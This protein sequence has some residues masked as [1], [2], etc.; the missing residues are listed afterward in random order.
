LKY[1]IEYDLDDPRATQQHR[2]I[3]LSNPF[4]KR[5]YREWYGIFISAVNSLPPGHLLEL[6]SGGGFLKDM[7]PSVITSDILDLPHVEMKIDAEQLPFE[8]KSMGGIFMINVFHHI[9]NP[10]NFLNEVYRTLKPGGKLIMIEPARTPISQFIYTR[11][12][13]E[14]FD[15]KAGWTIESGKP[16]TNSNQAL[17][18]IF[19]ERDK[20]IFYSKWP[21]LRI[22][23]IQYHSPVKYIVSGGVSRRPF[24]PIWSYGFFSF[25]E[26]MVSP[27]HRWIGLF[28]TIEIERL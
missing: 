12:H 13:H 2:E 16:M 3:I 19:F 18:Y 11:F 14:P 26:W 4:L 17:A 5:L 23:S 21:G 7:L 1:H 22:N 27:L 9:P 10:E 8:D 6:G 20:S 28:E 15:P 25:C 24:V